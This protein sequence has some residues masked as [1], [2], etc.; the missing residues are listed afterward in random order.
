MQALPTHGKATD[1]KTTHGKTGALPCA[2]LT[3][4][5]PGRMDGVV[6]FTRGNCGPHPVVQASTKS[7]RVQL[8][9]FLNGPGSQWPGLKMG[10][11]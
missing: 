5:F 2:R 3:H 7:K 10:S 8:A 4:F 1:G 11:A 9:H 6:G